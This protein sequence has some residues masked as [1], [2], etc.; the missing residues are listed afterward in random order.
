MSALPTAWVEVDTDAIRHNYREIKR[1]VGPDVD[2]MAVIKTNGCGH[3]LELVAEALRNEAGWFGVSTVEEGIRARSVAPN[4]RILVFHPCGPWNA[5]ALVEHDLIATVDCETGASALAEAGRRAGRLPMAHL[6]IDTGMSRFGVRAG[7]FETMLRVIAVPG[8]AW[9]GVYTHLS[10]AA[11]RGNGARLHLTAFDAALARLQEAGFQPPVVHAL[12]SAGTLRFAE[13]R[14]R[15]VR[16]GTLIYGQYQPN[17]PH[18]LNLKP[19][20]T[21]K[22]RIVSL[23]ELPAG[24]GVGYG[25][26]GITRRPSRIATLPIGFADGPTLLPRSAFERERGVRALVKKALGR[27]RMMVQTEH[28]AA[29]VIGRVASQ[30]MML[31]VTDLPV[32]KL[33]DV[34]EV[35]SRRLVVGEHIPRVPIT[36]GTG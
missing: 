34:V 8:I 3:G 28:G 31:D 25:A 35:P 26:E 24:T 29:P 11:A 18:S 9:D 10:I 6:K 7:D 22:A 16:C 21:L 33:G 36:G 23:R 4:S 12:N 13:H 30:S 14:Y 17:V 32:V 5:A 19:T 1:F 2:V 15:L 27:D 20:W